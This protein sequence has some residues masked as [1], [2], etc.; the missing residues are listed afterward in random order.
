M[1]KFCWLS[2]LTFSRDGN[3]LA[4]TGP[5]FVTM[6]GESGSYASVGQL[7]EQRVGG[8]LMSATAVVRLEDQAG[9]TWL[10]MLQRDNGAK[11][12]PGKWQFP[13]GRCAP[14]ELPLTT[15]CRELVEEVRIEGEVNDWKGARVFV[16]GNEVEYLTQREVHSFRARYVFLDNTLEV[17]Y[18]MALTVSSPEKVKLSDKEPYGRKV[19][20]MSPAGACLLAAS[21][22][23]TPPAYAILEKEFPEELRDAVAA[24]RERI[25]DQA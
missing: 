11:V 13:A 7:R 5:G 4:A 8:H 23:V 14:E 3:V 22:A 15:A 9:K 17:Y 18:P 25:F 2:D 21:G 6:R 19:A 20:L 24:V 10:L 12:D 16:G 1:E